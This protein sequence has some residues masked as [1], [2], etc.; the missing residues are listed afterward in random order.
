MVIESLSF[1]ISKGLPKKNEMWYGA[2]AW[3]VDTCRLSPES[4]SLEGRVLVI[5]ASPAAQHGQLIAVKA[6]MASNG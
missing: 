2:H 4:S 6:P 3:Y 1:G 5:S